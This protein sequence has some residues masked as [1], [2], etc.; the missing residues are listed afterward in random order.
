[1]TKLT[2]NGLAVNFLDTAVL[3]PQYCLDL[4][5][6]FDMAQCTVFDGTNTKEALA[7]GALI[8]QKRPQ[9]VVFFRRWRKDLPDERLPFQTRPDEW[10]NYMRDALDMGLTPAAYNESL[11]NPMTPITNYSTGVIKGLI[12]LEKQTGQEYSSVH[13]KIAF[14]NPGGY[15]VESLLPKSDPH[16]RPDGY[17]E[18]DDL[19]KLAASVNK[20][21]IDAG[22]FPAVWVAPHAY[23]PP[24]GSASGMTD[25][26]KEI[27]RR[28]DVYGISHK[29]V[30]LA[31]GEVGVIQTDPLD[32]EQGWNGLVDAATYADTFGLVTVKDFL[33]FG[34]IPHIFSVGRSTY[35]QYGKFDLMRVNTFWD[36]LEKIVST[37]VY[38]LPYWY[39]QDYLNP[40][41]MPVRPDNMG[42]GVKLNIVTSAAYINLRNKRDISSQDIGDVLPGELVTIFP[43]TRTAQGS[44]TWHYISR[45]TPTPGESREG[46]INYPSQLI[47]TP[48]IVVTPPVEPPVTEPPATGGLE[49]LTISFT[50]TY[51]GITAA[52]REKLKIAYA[53]LHDYLD[54]L[55]EVTG[56]NGP[57][58]TTQ[59]S[60]YEW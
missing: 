16:Y 14:G 45:S 34:L 51:E 40:A 10:V 30:P 42:E 22:K 60:P 2:P 56:T 55:G 23:F 15:N 32:A 7:T 59:E 13:F 52:R 33:P 6:R 5:N 36:R 9:S 17:A 37:G 57:E 20:P 11:S 3:D 24:S 53:A 19:W 4:M 48:P 41:N 38:R 58:I 44:Y 46:W 49:D 26:H 31:S 27:I 25:R 12:D 28:L 39:G 35:G 8:R 50:F 54:A 21:R 29:Y 18:S 47:P 43:A 1:M